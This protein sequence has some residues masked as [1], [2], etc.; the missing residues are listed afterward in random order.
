MVGCIICPYIYKWQR[1][2]FS[3]TQIWDF[4]SQ[5]SFKKPEMLSWKWVRKSHVYPGSLLHRLP[6]QWGNLLVGEADKI[7]STQDEISVIGRFR[8]VGK[9][10]SFSL[11]LLYFNVVNRCLSSSKGKFVCRSLLAWV[12]MR[13]WIVLVVSR[14]TLDCINVGT[15]K[16]WSM[17]TENP[18]I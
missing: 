16:A 11:V 5:W 2:R 9:V 18:R 1:R 15:Y 6:N 14:C 10:R 17:S 3:S 7:D 8:Y 13:H 4:T 12:S